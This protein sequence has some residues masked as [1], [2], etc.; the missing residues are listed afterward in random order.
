M[1]NLDQSKSNSRRV[2]AED[3]KLT[4]MLYQRLTWRQLL[5]QFVMSCTHQRPIQSEHVLSLQC[6]VRLHWLQTLDWHQCVPWEPN[7][8]VCVFQSML[9]IRA[10]LYV[11]SG[12]NEGSWKL[13]WG[14]LHF[15]RRPAEDCTTTHCGSQRH[16][17]DSSTNEQWSMGGWVP[18]QSCF[19][20]LS[21]SVPSRHL[22]GKLSF[23]G[24]NLT[25][26]W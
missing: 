15:V 8:S 25:N 12:W 17:V 9:P 14:L 4:P 13:S 18:W 6:N 2:S 24:I 1:S 19:N 3:A 10:P 7:F 21:L 11:M 26:R 5:S 20:C 23:L 22:W 16:H